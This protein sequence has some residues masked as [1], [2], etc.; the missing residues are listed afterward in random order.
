MNRKALALT[1]TLALLFSTV[2]G[3]QLVNFAL[4]QSVENITINND[5][6]VTPSSAPLTISGNVYTLNRDIY[7]S[8]N[9][10]KSYIIFA[11]ILIEINI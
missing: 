7:G 3:T 6:S 2:A 10:E 5:G 11:E 4:T 9:I 1:F 8:I